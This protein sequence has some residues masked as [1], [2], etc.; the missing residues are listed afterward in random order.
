M[1]EAQTLPEAVGT[2]VSQVRREHGFTLDQ[3]A[4][5]A[6]SHGASWS[7]SSVSNIERGQASLTLPTL[8]LLALALGELLGRPLRLSELLGDVDVLALVPGDQGVVRRAWIDAALAGGA[9]ITSP[10]ERVDGDDEFDEFD[11]ELELEATRMMGEMRGRPLTASEQRARFNQALEE[12]QTP[13]ALAERKSSE[14]AAGSLAEERAAKKLQIDTARLRELAL[15]LWTRPLEEEALRRAGLDS[16][17][18]ARGRVTRVLV[19]EIRETLK[20]DR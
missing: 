17:P 14:S 19:D 2:Y 15:D 6:R 7:A 9:V 13:P 8:L 12:L 20:E 5:A 3:I 10:N 11:E 1:N 4:R 16:T 18:Q